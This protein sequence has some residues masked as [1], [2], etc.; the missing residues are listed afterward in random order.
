MI[1]LVCLKYFLTLMLT[2]NLRKIFLVIY[3]AKYWN[4]SHNKEQLFHKL[5]AI[6]SLKQ[7]S[8]NK[9]AKWAKLLLC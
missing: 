3:Y 6:N 2:H 1:L 9:Y 5:V 4:S 7:N 8:T